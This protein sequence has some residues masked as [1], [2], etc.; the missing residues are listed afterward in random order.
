MMSGVD[1]LR[2]S[3]DYAKPTI[4]TGGFN[5]QVTVEPFGDGIGLRMTMP[6]S[7]NRR[8]SWLLGILSSVSLVAAIAVFVSQPD[9]I[10][11]AVTALGAAAILAAGA[12]HYWKS[13]NLPLV[14]IVQPMFIRIE[15]GWFLGKS[16]TVSTHRI[17]R[18]VVARRGPSLETLRPVGDLQL[19]C[20]LTMS[21]FRSLEVAELVDL[22]GRIHR[23]T[24]IDL[25][26]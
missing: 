12:Y 21:L 25:K 6:F 13:P 14:V 17:R 8:N 3:L 9:Q 10:K 24:G 23:I 5:S 26:L 18:L 11:C 15:N 16:R 22:A 1:E 20:T 4:P 2:P 19:C 7:T